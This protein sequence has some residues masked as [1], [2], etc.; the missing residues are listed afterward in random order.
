MYQTLTLFCCVT[1]EQVQNQ[2]KNETNI[3]VVHS[4]Q[5]SRRDR[6]HNRCFFFHLCD[7]IRSSGVDGL[8]RHRHE[9][10]RS[11]KPIKPGETFDVASS[12]LE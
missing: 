9:K 1:H 6:C 7:V 5:F 3:L 2:C 8:T 4:H 12:I 11:A 10:G